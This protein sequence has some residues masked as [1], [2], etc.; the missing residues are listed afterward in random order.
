[1]TKGIERQVRTGFDWADVT[2]FDLCW[3]EYDW[4]S[5][6]F[7]GGDVFATLPKLTHR[8]L[9]I[10]V[11]PGATCQFRLSAAAGAAGDADQRSA[12]TP[13]LREQEL[14]AAL[15]QFVALASRLS[16][17]VEKQASPV[18]QSL[19]LNGAPSVQPSTPKGKKGKSAS[20][21]QA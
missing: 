4:I 7:S 8:T 16:P 17:L 11:I 10:E 18:Q 2:G 12:V 3:V 1:V 13:S 5:K 6:I 9:S 14:Q 21:K 20:P 15:S 19:E